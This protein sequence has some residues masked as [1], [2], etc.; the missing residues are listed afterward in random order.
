MIKASSL[1]YAIVLSL[2][3]AIVSSSLI[4]FAYLT[5]IQFETFEINQRLH[6]NADSGLNLLLSQQ[7]IIELNEKKSID[8][9]DEGMDS[10]EL[11]RKL[12]GA[13]ELAISKAVFRNTSVIRTAQVGNSQ[14]SDKSYSV[15][16]VDED[17]TLALC[18]ETVLKGTAFVPKAEVKKA[19]I[20][21]QSFIGNELVAG[22]IKPSEKKLPEFN[23]NI[24]ENIQSIMSKKTMTE[25]DSIVYV[26]NELSEDSVTNS[27]M[28]HTLLL[29]GKNTIRI[30][31]GFYSGNIAII[32]DKQITISSAAIM[33]DVLVFAP[34]VIVEKEFKG[35]LQIYASDS[36]K[37]DKN[38]TLAYP[39]VVGMIRNSSSPTIA[40][41]VLSDNDTVVGNLFAYKAVGD[42]TKQS[43]LIL[44][45][46]SFVYGQLY[47]NGY[48]DIKGTVYGSLMCS[49]IIL[50]TSSS[51][52]ENHLLNVV[53]DRSKLSTHFVGI[54]L[55]NEPS[56]KQVAKWVH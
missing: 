6:L 31:A 54:N 45:A 43:A 42:I 19:Y 11:T 50:R 32:S 27:F 55:V 33:H 4:L 9:Y 25:N 37:I 49:K 20:E 26:G 34:K 40:A 30:S 51:V 1:F 38:V 23:K 29:I 52:Y 22:Q 13:Y 46:K 12:W 39:S 10:V 47:S 24:L 53:I 41:I 16:L 3:I 17:K 8:L 2:I 7:S 44:P 36:V 15:Y 28:N 18:G 5:H 14:Q 48:V 35:N 21:G 56:Y